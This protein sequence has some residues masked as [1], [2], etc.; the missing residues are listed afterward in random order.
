MYSFGGILFEVVME[1]KLQEYSK[2][3]APDVP[4]QCSQEVAD[5]ISSCLEKISPNLRPSA[6]HCYNVLAQQL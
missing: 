2:G 1:L 6:Q 5:L 3:I 4:R